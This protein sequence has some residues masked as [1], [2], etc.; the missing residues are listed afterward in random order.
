MRGS[1]NINQY[2]KLVDRKR[3]SD[4]EYDS[5][6]HLLESKMKYLKERIEGF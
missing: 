4:V 3:N 6:I 1:H 5:K 2:K